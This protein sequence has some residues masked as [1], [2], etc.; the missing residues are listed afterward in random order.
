[1]Y[2][3]VYPR[4]LLREIFDLVDPE[5][6]KAYIN[7]GGVELFSV[8]SAE[9]MA[10]DALSSL[11]HGASAPADIRRIHMNYN[12]QCAR[13]R[14]RWV[15]SAKNLIEQ[16]ELEHPKHP[17]HS[18]LQTRTLISQRDWTA[19]YGTATLEKIVEQKTEQLDAWANDKNARFIDYP[20]FGSLTPNKMVAALKDDLLQA[21]LQILN[22]KFRYDVQGY[23]S[24]YVE[25][26]SERPFFQLKPERHKVAEGQ[27]EVTEI[28]EFGDETIQ[29]VLQTGMPEEW[30]DGT[31]TMPQE[32]EQRILMYIINQAQRSPIDVE[33]ITVPLVDL[34]HVL[35]PP[36][37]PSARSY[38][39]TE[40]KL[41][42]L[43]NFTS[44]AYD[45]N[46]KWIA[47][48]NFIEHILIYT[49]P[50]THE[51]MVEIALGSTLRNAMLQRRIRSFKSS[52]YT[53]LKQPLSRLLFL[54]LQQER[55]SAYTQMK[56][57]G[58]AFRTVVNYKTLLG[59]VRFQKNST[60]RMKTRVL[61]ESLD[62]F[63]EAHVILRSYT[64]DTISGDFQFDF[65]DLSE[66]EVRDMLGEEYN[67]I[68]A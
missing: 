17:F 27:T 56:K 32:K 6:K 7:L 35:Y 18:L 36:A 9:E 62:E 54:R 23:L 41:K 68:M 30:T 67:A 40:Q 13:K 50:G 25:E 5:L 26:M 47:G 64:Y 45:Q 2:E 53:K 22:E 60:K 29:L 24:S 1:M 46:G 3:N 55:I 34:V 52:D 42:T 15:S 61:R 57:K 63:V 58:R 38:A 21:E 66:E 51:R 12:S 39:A 28:T 65:Y 59:A 43:A 16:C 14:R 33:Q 4:T 31:V 19:L 44:N 10:A 11:L 20:A 48:Y 37:H 49:H 8:V